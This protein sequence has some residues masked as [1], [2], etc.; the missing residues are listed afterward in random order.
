MYASA[1]PADRASASRFCR[2]PNASECTDPAGNVRCH[3]NGKPGS[4]EG[5]YHN[6][7]PSYAS[8]RLS[9]I[10]NWRSPY[11][12]VNLHPQIL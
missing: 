1:A 10:H 2:S 9:H 7:S 8:S 4:A 12:P 3:P 11:P 5:H 6:G